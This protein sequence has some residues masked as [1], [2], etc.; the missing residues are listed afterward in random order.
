MSY[1][2]EKQK[3]DHLRI[4][5]NL[6]SEQLNAFDSIME[7]IEKDLG[8]QVFVDG[9]VGTCKTYLWKTIKT[10]LCSKGKVV[11]A[12][13]SGETFFIFPFSITLPFP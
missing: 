2:K 11:L 1:N 7:S 12:V 8:T 3:E 4:F 5:G 10:K 13:V 9:Y 6:N